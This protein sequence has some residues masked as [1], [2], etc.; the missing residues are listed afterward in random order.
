[1]QLGGADAA[2][3][4]LHA[5]V[6]EAVDKLAAQLLDGLDDIQAPIPPPCHCMITGVPGSPMC[7][8]CSR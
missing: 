6:T 4:T 8:G 5:V 2:P 1:M 3:V 7:K